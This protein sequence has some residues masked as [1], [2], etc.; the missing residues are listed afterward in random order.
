MLG[1]DTVT[2]PQ[3]VV[4]NQYSARNLVPVPSGHQADHQLAQPVHLFQPEAGC[5]GLANL[6]AADPTRR[7]A[8]TTSRPCS[9][10]RQFSLRTR[11]PS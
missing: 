6:T 1:I 10:G 3:M 7:V 9:P 8:F 4:T 2:L 11:P 5:V